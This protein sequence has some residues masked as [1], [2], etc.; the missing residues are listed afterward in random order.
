MRA[1]IA[2]T[3]ADPAG[4]SST[5]LITGGAGSGK[6][7]VLARLVTLSDPDFL[8]AWAERVAEIPADLRPPVGAVDVA[9]LATRKYPH[10]VI[11]QIGV[12]LDADPR[13]DRRQRRSGSRAWRRAADSST[14]ARRRAGRR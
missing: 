5:L 12:A 10:E 13:T 9:V 14:P 6:S 2:H 1:L 8:T 7:A 11:A 4:P 3:A